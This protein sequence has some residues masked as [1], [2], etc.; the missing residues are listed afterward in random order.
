MYVCVCVI[1]IVVVIVVVVF[2][3]C[4]GTVKH[5]TDMVGKLEEKTNQLVH[6]LKE[7]EKR[8]VGC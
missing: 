5:K 1:I 3:T 2:K 6:T 7:M 4:E 8:Y